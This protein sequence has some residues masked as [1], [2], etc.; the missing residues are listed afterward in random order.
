[1]SKKNKIEKLTIK[2][3][4]IPSKVVF[5]MGE[6]N[7]NAY[8]DKHKIGSDWHMTNDGLATDLWNEKHGHIVMI[9]VTSKSYDAY[10]MKG[11]I[12][13]EI[14]HTVDFICRRHGIDDDEARAY[15]AQYL[16]VKIMKYY[17]KQVDNNV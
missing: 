17:D 8:I 9:S 6:E 11:L 14:V 10:Q 2:L 4:F 12:V 5:V 3:D 16:Y 15:L 7:H 13:H 1:M